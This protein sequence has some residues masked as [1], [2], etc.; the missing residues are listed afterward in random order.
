MNTPLPPITSSPHGHQGGDTAVLMRRVIYALLPAIAGYVWYFGW[1]IV[2]N[3]LIAVVAALLAEAAI[4]RLRGR[5]V[6]PSLGDGSAALT[7]VLLAFALP[8]LAP[9]WLPTIGA[10]FAI[11]FAKQL[12]GGLGHNP[13]NPAMAGYVLLL[14]SFPREMTSWLPPT[15]VSE[16]FP[17]L[18]DTLGYVFF[19][20]LPHGLSLD[21][22]TAATPLDTVRSAVGID[23]ALDELRQT[24]P[25]FGMA[26]GHG[27]TTVNA[28][29]LLGGAWLL[30]QRI[31]TW[32]VPV[33]ML[34]TLFGLALLFWLFDPQHNPTPLFHLF[35]GAAILGAFF[36]ATDP[37]SGAT[38]PRGRLLFGAGCGALT[39]VIRTWGG[40]PDGVAFSVLLMNMAAPLLDHY[41]RPRIY[42]HPRRRPRR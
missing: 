6:A 35:S 4:L 36:I 5:P 20:H 21:A 37:V 32:H 12:Y 3:I 17:G 22:V 38:T 2:I 25:L 14:I 1:G 31:I 30:W 16:Y 33:A 8:P 26:G 19:G 27:W 29:L 23:A 15:T 39:F 13:F 10:L 40:Y 18:R 24:S 42:G 34:G 9:W 28:L 41:S 11:V 7:A